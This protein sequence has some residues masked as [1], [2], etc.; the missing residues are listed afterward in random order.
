M[1]VQTQHSHTLPWLKSISRELYSLDAT[2]LLGASPPFPWEKLRESFVKAFSLDSLQITPGELAWKEKREITQG[3]ANPCFATQ[4]SATGLDGAVTLLICKEDVEHIMAQVLQIS[5]VVSELQAEDVVTSFHRFLSIEAVCLLNMLEYDP[6]LSFKIISYSDAVPER[7]L[8]QD[9]KITLGKEQIA[10]RVI[11]SSEFRSSWSAF[12]QKSQPKT[13]K[14]D[15]IQTTVHLEAGRT[16]IKLEELLEIH[17]GDFLLLDQMYY[18]EDN[19]KSRLL[20][21]L[22]GKPLFRA[23]LKDGSL[24]ILE[25]PLQHEVYTPMVEQVTP[26]DVEPHPEHEEENPFPD[27]PEDEDE[28]ESLELVEA[29]KAEEAEA[30]IGQ[31]PKPKA[32][33]KV[34]QSPPSS[35][36]LSAN[37]IPVTV[38]VEVASIDISVQK[39]LELAPGN[40]LDL[41]ITPENGV[42]L[43]VN[44]R[45]VGRG[46]LLKIGETLGVRILQIGV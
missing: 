30:P 9:I 31:T 18:N 3:I 25:I 7:A 41:N 45:V 23:S 37:D 6:R 38:I 11:I 44:G 2:P 40:V 34:A 32:S 35:T 10:A 4:C 29:A 33:V 21:T 42:N 15:Q 39:L 28:D 46:E 43:V 14:L 19:E 36:K 8:C 16:N 1:T 13:A 26:S 5:E 20:L 17:P 24:H 12:F 27:V 22:N